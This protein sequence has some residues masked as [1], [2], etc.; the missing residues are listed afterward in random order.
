MYLIKKND[1]WLHNVLK[2]ILKLKLVLHT[3]NKCYW[4]SI[5]LTSTYHNLVVTCSL[6]CVFCKYSGVRRGLADTPD[7]ACGR[8]VKCRWSLMV[9]AMLLCWTSCPALTRFFVSIIIYVSII[10]FIVVIVF[11][12]KE[13]VLLRIGISALSFCFK[14]SLYNFNEWSAGLPITIL[15]HLHKAAP[16]KFFH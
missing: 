5:H 9:Y 13:D 3:A 8:R 4:A 12:A 7:T 11:W 6:G 10:F 14:Y 16:S 2:I 1:S 15:A